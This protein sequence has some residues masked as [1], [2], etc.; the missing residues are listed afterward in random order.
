MTTL[1]RNFTLTGAARRSLNHLLAPIRCRVRAL[2]GREPRWH[3]AIL[4]VI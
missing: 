1:E 2:L 4:D 3:T